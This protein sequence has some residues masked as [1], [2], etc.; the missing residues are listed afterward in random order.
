MDVQVVDCTTPG[1]A[2]HICSHEGCMSLTRQFPADVR[3]CL[4]ERVTYSN[5]RESAEQ[6]SGEVACPRSLL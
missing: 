3:E 5:S 2:V 4:V 6:A 1:G